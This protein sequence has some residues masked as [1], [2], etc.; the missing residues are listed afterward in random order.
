MKRSINHF[1]FLI[2][3]LFFAF[4]SC[5]TGPTPAADMYEISK[6]SIE[7]ELKE[8][9]YDSL[10]V[11]FRKLDT[12]L[13]ENEMKLLYYGQIFQSNFKE[14]DRIN[15]S[16]IFEDI[17]SK[18]FVEANK[19]LE[20]VLAQF[21]LNLNAL[22]LQVNMQNEINVDSSTTNH[23]MI[24]INRLFDAI[25]STG[26]G[27]DRTNA[28]DVVSVSDEYFICYRILYTE[29]VTGQALISRKSRYYD[30]LIVKP[31]KNYNKKEVWF[32]VTN[33]FGKF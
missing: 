8:G 17:R 20:I 2:S 9:V 29:D 5:V 18:K 1:V 19:K 32:D 33:I 25:L 24:L 13:T 6:S 12:N 11:R 16:D 3:L 26:D 4:T 28:I 31:N 27:E 15:F 30:K 22:Y 10:V 23:K 7:K 21:P 14:Y